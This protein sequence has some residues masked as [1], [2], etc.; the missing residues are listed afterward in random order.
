MLLAGVA[1]AIC[2]VDLA[3]DF[4]EFL[5]GHRHE[6]A[7]V[8]LFKLCLERRTCPLKVQKR[9]ANLFF[10]FGRQIMR[11]PKTRGRESLRLVDCHYLIFGDYIAADHPRFDRVRD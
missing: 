2:S 11:R 3:N 4:P 1:D 8:R 6:L 10:Q 7:L 5:I 9:I